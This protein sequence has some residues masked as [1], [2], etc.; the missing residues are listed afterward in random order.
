MANQAYVYVRNTLE[1][2]ITASRRLPDASEASI[3]N[4]GKEVKEK[5]TLLG[6]DEWIVIRA[7]EGMDTRNCFLKV[8]ADV[9]LETVHSRSDSM[10]TIKIVPNRLPPDAPTTVNVTA[11]NDEPE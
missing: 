2:G 3:T 7:P 8:R 10:W 11:G 6:P 5:L 9:D 4:V 1:G